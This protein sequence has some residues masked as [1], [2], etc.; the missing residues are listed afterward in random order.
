MALTDTGFR[1]HNGAPAGDKLSDG[2]SMYLL[3]TVLELAR[4]VSHRSLSELQT[5]SKETAE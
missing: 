2:G 3:V 4:M 1:L 5:Y